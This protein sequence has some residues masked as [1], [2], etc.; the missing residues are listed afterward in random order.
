MNLHFFLINVDWQTRCSFYFNNLTI[1]IMQTI[2]CCFQVTMIGGNGD[3]ITV[4]SGFLQKSLSLL[5]VFILTVQWLSIG[6]C[7]LFAF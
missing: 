3:I 5:Q 6:L 1:I 2:F 4:S 7:Y